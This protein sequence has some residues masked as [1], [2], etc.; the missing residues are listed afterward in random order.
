MISEEYYEIFELLLI[1]S[2]IMLNNGLITVIVLSSLVL[3]RLFRERKVHL[4]SLKQRKT[5]I[6]NAAKCIQTVDTHRH[7]HRFVSVNCGD[8]P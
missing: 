7:T 2:F 8:F 3:M 1:L 6:E 4:K 5:W